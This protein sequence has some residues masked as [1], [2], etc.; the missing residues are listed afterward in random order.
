MTVGN[1]C[2]A[3]IKQI[4]DALE[5]SANNALRHQD[6]TMAQVGVL[7]A[8]NDASDHELHLKEL[9]QVLRVAQSTAAGI[10][11][12]LEQKGFVEGFGDSR[13]RRIKMVRLTP[14]GI[15]CCHEAKEI[16]ESAERQLLSS[17]TDTEQGI[18]MSLLQKVWD[19]L[20]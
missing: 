18:L 19:G 9:E 4:H 6:L 5:K 12:R 10:V 20:L 11:T 2:G 14:A 8:L 17:L 3:F 1:S 13:D 15:D 16:M 7:L